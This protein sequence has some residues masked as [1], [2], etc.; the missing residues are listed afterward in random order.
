MRKPRLYRKLY[1]QAMPS[2]GHFFLRFIRRLQSPKPCLVGHLLHWIQQLCVIYWWQAAT[3]IFDVAHSEAT[4]MGPAG[5]RVCDFCRKIGHEDD[6]ISSQKP[7]P[8]AFVQQ[9]LQYCPT[10]LQ[11][12]HELGCMVK[13]ATIHALPVQALKQNF[14][15]NPAPLT[16]LISLSSVL[17]GCVQERT[18][19]TESI[20]TGALYPP[21][22][23]CQRASTAVWNLYLLQ[24]ASN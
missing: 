10:R 19:S 2:R 18:Y 8:Y 5:R 21:L 6:L 1:Q 11:H 14:L 7:I 12:C 3:Y 4:I 22:S 13:P 17:E 16:T 20:R 9:R 24:L 23:A 15:I